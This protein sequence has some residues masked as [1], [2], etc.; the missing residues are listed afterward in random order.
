MLHS[1]DPSVRRDACESL[2][3]GRSPESVPQLALMLRDG[4]TGVRES[5]LNALIAIGGRKVAE[6]VAPLKP[7]ISM[8]GAMM[9]PASTA[10]ASHG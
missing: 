1:A 4:D 8:T 10:P 3:E 2:G 7:H 6:A 5:A 9:P